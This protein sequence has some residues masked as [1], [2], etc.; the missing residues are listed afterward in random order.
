MAIS[1]ITIADIAQ[2]VVDAIN[3]APAGTFTV[4]AGDP[5]TCERT[6]ETIWD[7]ENA[8]DVTNVDGLRINVSPRPES[9][10]TLNRRRDAVREI[11]VDVAI[12]RRLDEGYMPTDPAATATIDGLLALV[13]QFVEFPCQNPGDFDGDAFAFVRTEQ[14]AVFDRGLMRTSRLFAARITYCFKAGN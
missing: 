9:R 1:V 11:K 12:Y 7:V 4:P 5:V 6:W 8:D 13:Q 14:D 3:D 2:A 10:Q